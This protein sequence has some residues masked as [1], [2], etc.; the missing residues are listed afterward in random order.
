VQPVQ[1]SLNSTPNST[2]DP[3]LSAVRILKTDAPRIENVIVKGSGWAQGVEYSFADMV[4]RGE[5]L[6]PIATQN[7]NTIEIHFDGPVNLASTALTLAKTTRNT[8][9][10]NG[11]PTNSTIAGNATGVTFT[12]DE[13]NYIAPSTSTPPASLAAAA[14]RSTANG[15]TISGS[16]P[17]TR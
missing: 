7:A 16:A 2:A 4:A 1:L 3:I 5:Q 11:V 6:R 9:D 13:Q 10:I 17:S 14:R 8:Q 15:R 12:Y